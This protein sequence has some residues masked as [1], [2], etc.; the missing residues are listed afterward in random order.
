LG[1]VLESKRGMQL[2]YR[3]VKEANPF[4]IF[5]DTDRSGQGVCHV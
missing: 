3:L 5:I 4:C 1:P 2:R